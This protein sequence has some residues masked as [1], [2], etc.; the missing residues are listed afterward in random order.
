MLVGPYL[1][2]PLTRNMKNAHSSNSTPSAPS[3]SPPFD[4]IFIQTPLGAGRRDHRRRGELRLMR[5]SWRGVAESTRSLL[6]LPACRH[7]Y[8][9][10]VDL[11][12]VAT[13]RKLKR[14]AICRLKSKLNT[15]LGVGNRAVWK[16]GA[17]AGGSTAWPAI[18]ACIFWWTVTPSRCGKVYQAAVHTGYS[19]QWYTG[20]TAWY[21]PCDKHDWG[22]V[23]GVLPWHRVKE[24]G[25]P[26]TSYF[27][28]TAQSSDP[29]SGTWAVKKRL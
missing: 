28:A 8:L 27:F 2:H 18:Y 15:S 22:L 25:R 19:V 17:G 6:Q 13:W 24:V 14:G 7:F 9:N 3:Y 4:G 26:V 12:R 20:E 23:A 16:A 10:R 1:S 29:V 5:R 11:T 21:I